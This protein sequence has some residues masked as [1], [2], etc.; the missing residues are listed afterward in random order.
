MRLRNR[1]QR[2]SVSTL[3]F[4]DTTDDAIELRHPTKHLSL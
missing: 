4:T 2:L 1:Q 3:L